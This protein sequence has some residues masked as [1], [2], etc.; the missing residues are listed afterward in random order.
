MVAQPL[1]L[2]RLSL[3]DHP[4]HVPLIIIRPHYLDILGGSIRTQPVVAGAA[5][6]GVFEY[7]TALRKRKAEQD[8]R[9]RRGWEWIV[10][11]LEQLADV[12]LGMFGVKTL[13]AG[14]KLLAERGLITIRE[15]PMLKVDRKRQYRLEVAA[16]RAEIEHWASSQQAADGTTAH[17]AFLPDGQA[18]LPNG[19][20][21]L[22]S[23]A[24]IV[25]DAPAESAE[26]VF[27]ESSLEIQDNPDLND[28]V[29]AA[30]GVVTSSEELALP[31]DP[32]QPEAD[33]T[34]SPDEIPPSSPSSAPPSP[35]QPGVPDG[36]VM[37][38]AG[39][40]GRTAHLVHVDATET[41][42]G[43]ATESLLDAPKPGRGYG[44]CP[45]C[46][47]KLNPVVR[48]PSIDQP[49]KDAIAEHLQKIPINMATSYTGTLANIAIN[50]WKRKFG[51]A[52][53]K[54]EYEG[55]ARSIPVFIEDYRSGYPSG[56][57]PTTT[58][59][60]EE[61]YTK[62]VAATKTTAA[63]VD[64][65]AQKGADHDSTTPTTNPYAKNSAVFKAPSR[66]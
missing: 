40:S 25:P 9:P 14:L 64:A 22:P 13:R 42:C 31:Y 55:V 6:L 48:K 15:N 53:F 26:S 37:R 32:S 65:G 11:S 1:Q 19:E 61:Y 2:Q 38:Y 24:A 35:S 33:P 8:P 43:K 62:F 34:P 41:A 4:E 7:W 51:R 10:K 17:L 18:L 59:G 28:S 16:V 36:Y 21:Q 58:I 30:T 44:M 39:G 29:A 50:V 20:A 52:L 49:V 5:L 12:L 3:I 63:P 57:L 47:A 66:K 45:Q 23:E 56:K 54:A 46:M 60:F 27:R